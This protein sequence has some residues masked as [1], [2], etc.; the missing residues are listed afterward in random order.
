MINDIDQ[1]PE[2]NV[3]KRPKP[4]SFAFAGS[5]CTI[6]RI[7]SPTQKHSE[8]RSLW[9]F[10][11]ASSGRFDQSLAHSWAPLPSEDRDGL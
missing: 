10:M 1:E 9:I 11:N 2:G 4:R 3:Q 5:G 6:L 7:F 8:H